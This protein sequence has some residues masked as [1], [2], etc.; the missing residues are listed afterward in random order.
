M[1]A[2]RPD[3]GLLQ[4]L[5]R[6]NPDVTV[7]NIGG[8]DIR[9]NSTPAVIADDIK[10]LLTGIQMSGSRVYYCEITGRGHFPKDDMLTKKSFNSQ[11]KKSH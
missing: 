5:K 6:Y 4:Q 11:R 8:N 7:I 3:D 1:A 9:H 2:H 10:K